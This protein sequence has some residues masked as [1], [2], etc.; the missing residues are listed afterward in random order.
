MHSRK[1]TVEELKELVE[2]RNKEDD[3]QLEEKFWASSGT[4]LVGN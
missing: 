2:F 3:N 4:L 1:V